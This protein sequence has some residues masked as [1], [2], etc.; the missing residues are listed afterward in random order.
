VARNFRTQTH[1]SVLFE[2]YIELLCILMGSW[3]T[4]HSGK[5]SGSNKEKKNPKKSLSVYPEGE[6]EAI[7]QDKSFCNKILP[8]LEKTSKDINVQPLSFVITQATHKLRWQNSL[9]ITILSVEDKWE[10]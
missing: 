2:F 7:Q 8:K 10:T 9:P 4:I 3:R 5:L 6:E 1:C